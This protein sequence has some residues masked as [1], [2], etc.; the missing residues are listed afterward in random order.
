MQGH[1]CRRTLKSASLQLQVTWPLDFILIRSFL[2][3]TL[4]HFSGPEFWPNCSLSW[5]LFSSPP[6]SEGCYIIYESLLPTFGDKFLWELSSWQSE[7]KR[8]KQWKLKSIG[9]L[10]SGK[11][12]RHMYLNIGNP[13]ILN[14]FGISLCLW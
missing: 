7:E 10:L 9:S 3:P 1:T 8:V 2:C 13:N 6:L 14:N 12:F 5:L 4:H 11:V